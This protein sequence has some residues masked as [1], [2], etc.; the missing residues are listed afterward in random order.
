MKRAS[1]LAFVIFSMLLLPDCRSD[2]YPELTGFHC[3]TAVEGDDDVIQRCS[4]SDEICICSSGSCARRDDTCEETGFRYLERPFVSRDVAARECVP[5]SEITPRD[6]D[7]ETDGQECSAAD[8][9]TS[10]TTSGMDMAT[11]V[12]TEPTRPDASD[13]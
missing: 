11:T 1:I 10:S 3:G 8:G 6:L 12:D 9:S 5:S 7:L 4:R 13:G 2:Y